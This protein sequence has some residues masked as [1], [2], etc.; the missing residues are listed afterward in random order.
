MKKSGYNKI[1]RLGTFLSK[2]NQ[3]TP[4]ILVDTGGREVNS[5]AHILQKSDYTGYKIKGIYFN[6][7]LGEAYRRHIVIYLDEPEQCG[8][9]RQLKLGTVAKFMLPGCSAGLRYDGCEKLI[10]GL[11]DSTTTLEESELGMS[12][13]S[14]HFNPNMR[15]YTIEA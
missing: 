4:I 7:P 10:K 5:I 12:V 15:N 8:Y 6:E 9:T 1:L 3:F 2:C 13:K 14:I 11:C